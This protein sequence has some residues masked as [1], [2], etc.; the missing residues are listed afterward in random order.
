MKLT[1]AEPTQLAHQI[2]GAL[3]QSALAASQPIACGGIYQLSQVAAHPHE[4]PD[5]FREYLRTVVGIAES[6]LTSEDPRY[7][8]VRSQSPWSAWRNRGAYTT[9]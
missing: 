7:Q 6:C 1:A 4:T 2:G 3:Q 9:F 8:A 5:A